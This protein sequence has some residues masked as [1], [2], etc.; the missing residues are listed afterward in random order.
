MREGIG[1]G[2]QYLRQFP[3]LFKWMNRCSGCRHLGHKPEM[4]ETI[5]PGVGASYLR[6][7]FEELQL[8]EHGLCEQCAASRLKDRHKDA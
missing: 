5:H 8:D 4:P 7:Y 2:Q 1:R 3:H 6:R